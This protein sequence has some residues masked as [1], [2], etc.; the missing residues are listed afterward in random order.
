FMNTLFYLI[1]FSIFV[2]SAFAQDEIKCPQGA[3]LSGQ[4]GVERYCQKKDPGGK[5]VNHG[6]YVRWYPGGKKKWYEGV[7][8]SGRPFGVWTEWNEEGK[9]KSEIEFVNGLE[10]AVRLW[11]AKGVPLSDVVSVPNLNG[12]IP[13]FQLMKGVSDLVAKNPVLSLVEVVNFANQRLALVGLEYQLDIQSNRER[14]YLFYAEG[15]KPNADVTRV[16]LDIGK[17]HYV[18]SHPSLFSKGACEQVLLPVQI[19]SIAGKQLELNVKGKTSSFQMHQWMELD[20]AKVY[21]PTVTSGLSRVVL[22]T[23]DT[24]SKILGLSK[25]G[26]RI[27]VKFPL[28]LIADKWWKNVMRNNPKLSGSAPY[29]ALSLT[30]SKPIFSDREEEFVQQKREFYKGAKPESAYWSYDR[31]Q[32]AG[33]VLG[34]NVPCS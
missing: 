21:D 26:K 15:A 6:L 4:E 12:K 3:E 10:S 17:N 25:D 27:I 34:Y 18:F 19:N 14:R 22:P 20:T 29:L 30:E 33:F 7:Y 11:D 23:G 16:V 9:K 24:V 28:F 13:N 5:L 1:I 32:E 31:F 8:S 2:G